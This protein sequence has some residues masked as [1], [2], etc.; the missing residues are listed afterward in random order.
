M[1]LSEISDVDY[2][3]PVDDNQSL[4][5][6]HQKLI[7]FQLQTFIGQVGID[8]YNNL[9]TVFPSCVTGFTLQQIQLASPLLI[10]RDQEQHEDGSLYQADDDSLNQ[11]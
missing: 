8:K 3:W 9:L 6:F 2:T 7:L 4:D 5:F 1:Y 10:N 11:V